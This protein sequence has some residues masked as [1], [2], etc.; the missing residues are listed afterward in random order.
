M[1]LKKYKYIVRVEGLKDPW[2][3]RFLEDALQAIKSVMPCKA[4]IEAVEE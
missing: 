4:S 1:T 2:E 3:Y